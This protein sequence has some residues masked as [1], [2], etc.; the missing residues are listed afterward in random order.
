MQKWTAAFALCLTLAIWGTSMVSKFAAEDV[1]VH[2]ASAGWHA[3]EVRNP[4]TP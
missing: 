2:T 1:A 3:L 4:L